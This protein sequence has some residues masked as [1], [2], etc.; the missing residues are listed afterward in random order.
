MRARHAAV[1]SDAD[2]SRRASTEAASTTPRWVRSLTRTSVSRTRAAPARDDAS[3]YTSPVSPIETVDEQS[4]TDVVLGR[5]EQA[6]SPRA[7]EISEALVRHLHAFVRE[8]EPT[9]EEWAAGIDFLTRTGHMCSPTRQE[10]ILLSDTLGVS[11]LVDAINHRAPGTTESTVLGPFYVDDP[12]PAELGADISGGREGERL[13]VDGTVR[14]A[15][16]SPITG[17]TV[18]TWH[19]DTEGYYDVQHDGE[20][21]MRARFTTDAEG[22]FRFW[23]IVP[24]SY[25]IPYDGP[26]GQMLEAQG[27]HPYR[28]A[29]VHF[30]IGA[31]GYDRLVTHLFVAGDEYLASDA[32]F[33]VKESLVCGLERHPAGTA[34]DGT[35]VAEP[36]AHLTYD[37][38]LGEA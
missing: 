38:V 17:A 36:Y 25:P 14:A 20:T 23:S 8:I 30:M 37:F 22:R 6:P 21:Y 24:S 31:P 13:Y 5:L 27:R 16:G 9:M 7:R 28:P 3:W 29:H 11:M 26:V 33:A 19:S 35:A 18:D 4:I 32:V 10:F 2:A 15:D 34:P 1:S 12:P